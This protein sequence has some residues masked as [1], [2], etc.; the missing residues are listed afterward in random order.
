[1]F[2]RL[3]RIAEISFFLGVFYRQLS[4]QDARVAVVEIQTRQIR[5]LAV[6]IQ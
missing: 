1:M 5:V 4:F 6:S 2:N 3:K